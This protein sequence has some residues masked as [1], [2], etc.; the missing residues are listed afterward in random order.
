MHTLLDSITLS[1]DLEKGWK[2]KGEHVEKVKVMTCKIWIG[3]LSILSLA[4]IMDVFVVV[5]DVFRLKIS[6]QFVI[7]K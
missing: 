3:K 7:T 5:W 1:F 4:L 6:R 2:L